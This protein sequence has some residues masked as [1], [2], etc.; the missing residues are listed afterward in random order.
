MGQ[1]SAFVER[2]FDINMTES[3]HSLNDPHDG[4]QNPKTSFAEENHDILDPYL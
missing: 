1:V 4:V 2:F 3:Q